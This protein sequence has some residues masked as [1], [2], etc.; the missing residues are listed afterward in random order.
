VRSVGI[1]AFPLAQL[2]TYKIFRI[3]AN[4]IKVLGSS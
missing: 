3:D 2:S 4:N 1:V